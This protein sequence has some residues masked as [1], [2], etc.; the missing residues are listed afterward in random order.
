[1]SS[2][3]SLDTMEIENTLDPEEV[4]ILKNLIMISEDT[5][6]EKINT[7][8]KLKEIQAITTATLTRAIDIMKISIFN[9]MRDLMNTDKKIN[10]QYI[11]TLLNKLRMSRMMRKSI[12]LITSM[13]D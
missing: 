11:I 2:I 6:I 5:V 7:N 12:I 8:N 9:K 13:I 4:H 1:M 3:I 10:Q